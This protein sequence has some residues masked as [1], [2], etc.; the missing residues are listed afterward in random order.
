[1][2][3]RGFFAHAYW[4]WLGLGALFGFVLLFNLG[5][6]LALTFLNREYRYHLR[7]N[8][9]Y[10]NEFTFEFLAKFFTGLEK[11]RAILTEESESNEQDSTIGGTVQLSTHGG[12]SRR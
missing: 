7:L 1:M 3:S 5:F 12:S 4:F 9:F 6:T 8:Y 11:P 10:G 2:K